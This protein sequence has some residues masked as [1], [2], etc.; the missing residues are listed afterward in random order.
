MGTLMCYLQHRAHSN[1]LLHVGIQDITAHVDFTAMADAALDAGMEING[2]ATQAHFLLSMGLLEGMNE[3]ADNLASYLQQ[4][5][6]VKRLTLPGEMGET[7]KVMV[8]SKDYAGPIAGFEL[9]DIRH[10]L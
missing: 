8:V 7:F 2:F 6:E 5:G 1:P 10:L 9:N 3:Q 4:T